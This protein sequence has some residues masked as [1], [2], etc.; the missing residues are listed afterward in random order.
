MNKLIEE[1]TQLLT[2]RYGYMSDDVLVREISNHACGE[3]VY[4]LLYGRY[5]IYLQSIFSKLSQTKEC[6]PDLMAE[7]GLHLIDNHCEAIRKFQGKSSFKTWLASVAHNLFINL[8]PQIECIYSDKEG[9]PYGDI[10]FS[11]TATKDVDTLTTFRQV[12]NYLPTAEQRIVLMKEAEGYNAKEIA[13]ILTE[14]RKHT[15]L[16][17]RQ[18]SN[19]VSVD[20]VYKIRQRAVEFLAHIMREENEKL[21]K[22][23]GDILFRDDTDSKL[24]RTANEDNRCCEEM[25]KY[26]YNPRIISNIWM[27]R[28]DVEIAA[29]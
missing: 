20:N 27:I 11:I 6:F 24:Y 29:R 21:Q 19:E 10:P 12:L 14:K 8:L 26:S 22:L 13:Q 15:N 23:D 28:A 7:L 5:R 25:A 4:Y 2:S 17:P 16:Q 1:D 3:M 9:M 18:K